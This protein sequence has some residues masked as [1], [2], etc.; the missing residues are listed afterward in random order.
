MAGRSD[1][2]GPFS[3]SSGRGG[4]PVGAVAQMVQPPSIT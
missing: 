4:G 2:G 1:R 3:F